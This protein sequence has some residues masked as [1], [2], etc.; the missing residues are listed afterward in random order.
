M[1]EVAG[2]SIIM[3]GLSLSDIITSEQTAH[4]NFIRVSKLLITTSSE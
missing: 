3:V 4:N 2:G 1:V